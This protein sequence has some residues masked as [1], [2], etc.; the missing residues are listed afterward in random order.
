MKS[1]PALQALSQVDWDFADYYGS[2]QFPTDINS[3]HWYPAIFVPQ[4]PAILVQAL[5]NIGDRVLDPFAGAG[6]TLIEASRQRRRFVGVDI[7]PYAVN[8]ARAKILAIS[9]TDEGWYDSEIQ[10]MQG[11]LPVDNPKKLCYEEGIDSEVFEWF[12]EKTLSE[13]LAIRRYIFQRKGSVG[14]LVRQVLFSSILNKCS[15]QRD[16]YTYIT[17]KC[18]PKEKIYR[19]AIRCYSEQLNL[20]RSAVVEAKR[21]FQR[22][23]DSDWDPLH[24]GIIECGDARNLSWIADDSID[25]VI[26]SPPYLGVNDYVRSMRLSW[27]LFPEE[28]TEMAIREEIG[29]RRKRNRKRASDEYFQD[30]EIVLEEIQRVLKPSG[31]LALVVGHGIGR[32]NKN[33][34]ATK[35]LAMLLDKYNFRVIF[36]RDRKIKFRRIQVPGV[37]T[38]NI[39]VLER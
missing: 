21:Q 24:D 8:I 18:F 32:V 31:F 36:Q 39:L 37:A 6:S 38:E 26:T 16:H 10:N 15:S 17:D 1:K 14:N 7:N 29:A 20:T 3:L 12:E 11:L 30:I 35:L 23:Y 28:G 5:S 9:S 4:I 27:L 34:T 13:L 2:R 33:D 22:I 25:L 19:P